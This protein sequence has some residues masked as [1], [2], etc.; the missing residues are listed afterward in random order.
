VRLPVRADRSDPAKPLPR[1]VLKFLLG[2]HAHASPNP[3][4]GVGIPRVGRQALVT[5]YRCGVSDRDLSYGG[6][7]MI[8]AAIA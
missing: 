7:R 4:A 2:E 5:S 6:L 3:R 8:L 1:E